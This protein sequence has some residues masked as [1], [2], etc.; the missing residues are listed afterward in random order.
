M[1]VINIIFEVGKIISNFFCEK[2]MSKDIVRYILNKENKNILTEQNNNHNT[3]SLN[4]QENNKI[5]SKKK[6]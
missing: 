2:K 6:K 3:H 4:K 1:S 5:S